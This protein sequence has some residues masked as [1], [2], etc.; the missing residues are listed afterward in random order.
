MCGNE[1]KLCT[2]ASGRL[3]SIAMYPE[4]CRYEDEAFDDMS[5]DSEKIFLSALSLRN[6][7]GLFQVKALLSKPKNQKQNKVN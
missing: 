5:E 4:I 3:I 6:C 2:L 1:I 7:C